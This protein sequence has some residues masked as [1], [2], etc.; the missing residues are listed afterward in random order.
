M[1]T[2]SRSNKKSKTYHFNCDWEEEFL[3]TM[4]KDKCKCLI[5]SLIVALPKR[6]NL[7]RH[8]VTAHANFDREFPPKSLTRKSEVQKLKISLNFQQSMFKKICSKSK[9]ATL[10][11]LRVSRLFIQHKKPFTDGELFKEAFLAAA[12]SLFENFKNKKEIVDAIKDMQLSRHTVTRRVET[13]AND[14]RSQLK[15][16]FENCDWFSL[17]FDESTDNSDMSQLS[18][19]VRFVFSDS[20][21]KEEYLKIL[22]VKERTRGEDIYNVL[23]EFI[24]SENIPLKKLVSIT[25]DGAPS[26]VGYERG[27]LALFKRDNDFP[28]FLS[29][30]CII[31][32]Q[33]LCGK[34]LNLDDV[35]K[36]AIKIINSIRAKALQRRL[37]QSLLESVDAQYGDLLLHNAVRW[38]SKGAIL[39]RFRKLLPHIKDF[40][41]ERND[42]YAELLQDKI[43]LQKLAFLTD[44]TSK[45][46]ELNLALQGKNKTIADMITTVDT[47]KTKLEMW[48]AQFDKK[49]LKHFSNLKDE[50][51]SNIEIYNYDEFGNM[52]QE[53]F[54]Q[55]QHRFTEFEKLRP[56]ASFITSPLNK[57]NVENMAKLISELFRMDVCG[58]E[59]QLVELQSDIALKSRD[60]LDIWKHISIERYPLLKDAYHRIHSCFASTYL[61]ESSFS[62]MNYMKSKYRTRLTDKHMDDCL[63]LAISNYEPNYMKIAEN[64]QCQTSH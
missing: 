20:T 35:M 25:T 13:I 26:M 45:L 34:M 52:L 10:A 51:G 7:N 57:I 19:F 64:I 50:I 12:D 15:L 36:T 27:C 46:N 28:D 29:Y 17:Q 55:I 1:S 33:S 9:M 43:W 21:V 6:G 40:V 63:C 61:C 5:C 62:H 16:D 58:L 37:F 18:I 4:D 53:I 48:I 2:Q 56:I 22:P 31:H 30:H 23:K 42:P 44:I 54:V 8:F 41:V 59:L 14:L 60:Q 11:S 3:F 49:D 47:F 38:L 39:E 32:Q 24:I